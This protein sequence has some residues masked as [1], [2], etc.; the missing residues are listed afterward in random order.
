MP[1]LNNMLKF[2]I[3]HVNFLFSILGLCFMG[4]AIYIMVANWGQLDPGFFQ[5]VGAILFIAGFIMALAASMGNFGIT[6]QRYKYGFWSG[7][8]VLFIYQVV[9]IAT[10]VAIIYLIF[11]GLIAINSFSNTATQLS[12]GQTPPFTST[13]KYFANKFN[14]F[15]FGAAYKTCTGKTYF[16]CMI[17]NSYICIYI[18]IHMIYA[19]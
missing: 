15:Y 8:R 16:V 17:I 10:L 9:L 2:I 13:E 1:R 12:V 18:L 19:L 3:F 11:I 7:R 4:L 6:H 14:I 5:G